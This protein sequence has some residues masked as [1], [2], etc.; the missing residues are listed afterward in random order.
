M[1][2]MKI[3]V[4]LEEAN[5][6]KD[7]FTSCKENKL[8]CPFC[9]QELRNCCAGVIYTC[10]KPDSCPHVQCYGSKELWQALIDTKKKLNR[11]EN[12]LTFISNIKGAGLSYSEMCIDMREVAKKALN[13]EHTMVLLGRYADEYLLLDLE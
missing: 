13:S 5:V 6:N 1:D 3:K 4:Y 2:D 7:F 8:K 10:S 11:Y 12:A 9:Q